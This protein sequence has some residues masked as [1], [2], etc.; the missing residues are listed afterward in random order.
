MARK[1]R[2]DEVLRALKSKRDL[3]IVNDEIQILNDMIWS[4]K[5]GGIIV[6]PAKQFDIGNGTWGKLDYLRKIHG[7]YIVYVDKFDY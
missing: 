7:Y 6:N 2:L 5:L 3:R 1:H 4:Q